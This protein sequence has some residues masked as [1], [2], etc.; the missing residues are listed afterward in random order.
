MARRRGDN[1][2]GRDKIR[3][4]LERAKQVREAAKN[5]K[6][7]A[8]AVPASEAGSVDA[9]ASAA[10]GGTAAPVINV[11]EKRA[12]L[13]KES[14]LEQLLANKPEKKVKNKPK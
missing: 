13:V 10:G 1:D 6:K 5:N 9:S 2:L 14:S 8:V 11:T 12:S 7:I 4:A 3:E